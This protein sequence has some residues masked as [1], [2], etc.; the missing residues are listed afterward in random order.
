MTVLREPDGF[1]MLSEISGVVNEWFSLA[2]GAAVSPDTPFI[3]W[4]RSKENQDISLPMPE[5]V[6]T[7]GKQ[8][9]PAWTQEGILHWYGAWRGIEVPRGRPA[10]DKVDMRGRDT[11]SEYRA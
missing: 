5:P 8:G 9:R 10:G 2:D 7:L 6:L 11:P 1:V 3:W 4:H